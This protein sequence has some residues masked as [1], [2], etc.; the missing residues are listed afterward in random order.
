LTASTYLHCIH[1]AL[2]TVVRDFVIA[3]L[4]YSICFIDFHR[5]SISRT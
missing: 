2:I 4:S 5:M 3:S 1:L